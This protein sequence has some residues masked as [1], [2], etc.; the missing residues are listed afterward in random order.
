MLESPFKILARYAL[1]TPVTV[2]LEMDSIVPFPQLYL[3]VYPLRASWAILMAWSWVM[4][5]VVSPI[6]SQIRLSSNE[7]ILVEFSML[8]VTPEYSTPFR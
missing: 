3:K 5:I 4:L 6:F 8:T 1:K 7:T 2:R